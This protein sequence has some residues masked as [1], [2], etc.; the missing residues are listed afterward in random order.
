MDSA[1]SV[2]ILDNA[3]CINTPEKSMNPYF[4]SPPSSY[5]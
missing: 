3:M 4:L 2:Q 1:T 5:G